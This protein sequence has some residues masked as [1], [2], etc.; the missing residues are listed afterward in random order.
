M[1]SILGL[2]NIM[3][4]IHEWFG[5]YARDH[6]NRTN[7]A[8]HWACVPVI[9]WCA[10]ALLWLIPVPAGFV[11]QGFWAVVAMF[12]T[13][14]FYRRL[15]RNLAWAMA[16]LFIVLAL[17]T[18][19]LYSWLGPSGLLW[20]AVVLFVLAWIAQFIG[21]GFE[22]QRPAFL[23]DLAYLLISP[24]WLMSKLMRRAGIRY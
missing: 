9:L 16:G 8:I 3:R 17:V 14:L 6:R 7:R 15:S 11:R 13:F 24:A 10:I 22:H 18:A 1:I 19:G 12:A 5:S 23:T 2:D 4:D 21:H 20:L